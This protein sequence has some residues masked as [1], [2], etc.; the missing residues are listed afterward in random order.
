MEGES[1]HAFSEYY[2]EAFCAGNDDGLSKL[3]LIVFY[4]HKFRKRRSILMR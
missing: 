4:I 2:L 3:D 1:A